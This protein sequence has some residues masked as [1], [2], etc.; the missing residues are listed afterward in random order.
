M[1]TA[2]LCVLIAALLPILFTGI[3]KF[4]GP[5]FNNRK[6]RIFQTQL[7]GF[8]ERAHWAHLNGFEAFPVFAAGVL[9]AAQQN[10]AQDRIDQLA[11]VF[12]AARVLYGAFYLLDWATMRSLAWVTGFGCSIAL[13]VAAIR[14]G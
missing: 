1:S 7:T 14:A 6:V 4:S 3:A 11:V 12:I 10:V 5:G 8:R 13:M 9:M 2:Y